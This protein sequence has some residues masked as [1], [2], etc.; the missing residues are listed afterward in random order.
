MSRVWNTN[1]TKGDDGPEKYWY[2]Y[3]MLDSVSPEKLNKPT[4]QFDQCGI[5]NI[6]YH[7]IKNRTD[8]ETG[9]DYWK[10][11][12]KMSRNFTDVLTF[13]EWYE[14]THMDEGFGIILMDDVATNQSD[15]YKYFLDEDAGNVRRYPD[16]I[17]NMKK[18]YQDY[19]GDWLVDFSELSGAA[20]LKVSILL[21]SVYF[22]AINI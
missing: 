11:E 3:N 12:P 7:E 10:E 17:E 2:N 1:Y 8:P 4:T 20:Y 9:E 14:I 18:C 6:Y 22:I 19:P 16:G 5:Q 21:G 13:M 15:V